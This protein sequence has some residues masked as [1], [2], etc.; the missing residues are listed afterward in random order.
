VWGGGPGGVG[1]CVV[2]AEDEVDFVDGESCG[3]AGV[4]ECVVCGVEGEVASGDDFA[5]P[6]PG[7]VECVVALSFGCG[8]DEGGF[9][10]EGFDPVGGVGFA[11]A[12]FDC[13]PV[14]GCGVGLFPEL[15][16]VHSH[17]AAFGSS[18]LRLRGWYQA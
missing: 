5:H 16:P 1:G 9:V 17:A 11:V 4:G 3:E 14:D 15:F 12:Y 7:S 2:G 18:S 13:G 8:G 10:A 6:V